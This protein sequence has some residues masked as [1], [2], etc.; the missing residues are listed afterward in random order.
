MSVSLKL[1]AS[2]VAFL[3]LV[4][5]VCHAVEPIPVTQKAFGK[6]YPQFAA[7]WLEWALAIPVSTNPILDN[8]GSF[9]AIGQSG[10]VWYLAGNLGGTTTRSLTVPSGTALFFPLVNNFWVNTPETGDE[11]W[12]PAWEAQVRQLLAS[13]VDGAHSLSLEVDG[14][15]SATVQSLRVASRVGTCVLPAENIVSPLANAGPH[16]C[17]GD[18]YWAL[19]EPLK[20]GQ[21]TIRFTGGF[22]DFSLDVT[23]NLTVKQRQKL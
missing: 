2:F 6:T 11:P 20:V 14:V 9:G 22:G 18:G 7:G 3:L 21:H 15:P 23:Y 1:P 4:S 5:N 8:D 19:L 12:S 13:T 17:V 10:K 16:E